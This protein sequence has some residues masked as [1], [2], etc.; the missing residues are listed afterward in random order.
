M[1]VDSLSGLAETY[2]RPGLTRGGKNPLKKLAQEF[3][4]LFLAQLLSVMKE[5]AGKDGFF[6]GSTGS[7]LYSSMMDQ[8]LAR[9]LAEKG[10]IGLAEPLYEY[11]KGRS[12]VTARTDP[13][14]P[15]P[16][17]ASPSP[18]G[19]ETDLSAVLTRQ[20]SGFRITSRMGW[21]QDP[22][23]GE[24][25]YHR[26]VD[27]AAPEGTP[28]PAATS[29][30]VVFNGW[31]GGYGNTVIIE[32]NHGQRVRYA[33]LNRLEVQSGQEVNQGQRIGTVGKT[34]RS[35]GAHLHVEIEE[36]GRFHNPLHSMY[37]KL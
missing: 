29:G 34:G 6:G 19:E 36:K 15:Q 35:T 13:E 20:L 33:H 9:S 18:R 11:L 2:M 32:N 31:Q 16:P 3:E 27:F 7:D 28:V 30:R 17:D 14:V 24:R 10:G 8:A 22:I 26:G 37:T 21:R 23:T 25:R 4:S 5:G 1:S 12:R